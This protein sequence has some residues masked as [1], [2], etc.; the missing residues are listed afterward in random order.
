MQKDKKEPK[1]L[2]DSL[3]LTV[4]EKKLLVAIACLAD[5]SHYNYLIDGISKKFGIP[6]ETLVQITRDI[7]GKGLLMANKKKG[8]VLSFKGFRAYERIMNESKLTQ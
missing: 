8:Y 3:V 5:N 2:E 1:K 6:S 7:L 4:S